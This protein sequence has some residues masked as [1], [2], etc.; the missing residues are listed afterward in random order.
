MSVGN[1]KKHEDRGEQESPEKSFSYTAESELQSEID[2][3]GTLD[4]D[5]LDNILNLADNMA[6]KLAMQTT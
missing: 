2:L 4:I 1:S 6:V 3:L 5:Q